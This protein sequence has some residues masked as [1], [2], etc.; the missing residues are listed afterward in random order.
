MIND[1]LNDKYECEY[2]RMN[3]N[4]NLMIIIRDKR[5]NINII[6]NKK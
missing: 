4:D 3:N 1:E 2:D 6:I 5:D